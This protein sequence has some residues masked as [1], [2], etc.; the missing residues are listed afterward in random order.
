MSTYQDAVDRLRAVL[1]T[2][3]AGDDLEL[4]KI[5]RARDPVLARYGRV[6]SA[7]R[8]GALTADEFREFL[9]F[10]N[11]QHWTG[12]NRWV[13]TL[14]YNMDV[15]RNSV[16]LLL[17]ETV[18]IRERVDAI[19]GEDGPFRIAGLGKAVV[20]P[21]LHV[22][23]PDRYGVWNQPSES[24]MRQLGIWPIEQQGLSAGAK[25][26]AIN[27]LLLRLKNDLG[28]DLWT[29][30][31]LWWR[32]IDNSSVIANQPEITKEDFETAIRTLE[33]ID[34]LD[35]R[36]MVAIRMEQD[37]I[38]QQLFKGKESERCVICGRPFPIDLL[39]AAH[40]KRR[41]HCSP[42]EKRDFT[43]NVLP[44]C[45]LGC[46]ELFERG[47]IVVRSG[48]T[49]KGKPGRTP[50]VEDYIANVID[51]PCLAYYRGSESYFEWHAVSHADNGVGGSRIRIDSVFL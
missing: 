40:I 51:R 30:D 4:G 24:G 18:P 7:D 1:E 26:E 33:E 27:S 14:T 28:I 38:R 6:F 19:L 12:I 23:G 17:N 35:D 15:L 43:N 32:V 34:E 50:P 10:E 9:Q 2:T 46:D 22:S 39:R 13:T 42:E 16:A 29:L 45:T 3:R 8:V 31:A 25:Y 47:Y 48:R 21:I 5:L 41:S 11:N 36:R 20:T 44:I 37:F 49:A